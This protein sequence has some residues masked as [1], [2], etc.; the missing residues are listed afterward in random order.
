MQQ[1]AN[2]SVRRLVYIVDDEP[3]IGELVGSFLQ[4]EGFAV[5]IFDHPV[6]ALAAFRAAD[7]KPI[8]LLTDFQMPEMSGLEL[9]KECRALHPE[10]RTIS[11]SGTMSPE[12]MADAGVIPD[13]FVRK[14]FLASDLR[15]PMAELLG[16]ELAK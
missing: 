1:Q 15:Q 11:I 4:M 3:M 10:L 16:L 5:E 14:P 12:D 9:I 2:S 8:M 13:R 6:V 7:P